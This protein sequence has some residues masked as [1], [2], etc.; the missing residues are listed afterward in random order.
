MPVKPSTFISVNPMGS[1]FKKSEHETVLRNAL[2]ISKRLGDNW[3]L[4]KTDYETERKKDGGYSGKESDIADVVLPY[5]KSAVVL[6]RVSE[7][8]ADKYDQETDSGTH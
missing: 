3:G 1:I 5:L 6:S 8:Y 7:R 4:L 2:I